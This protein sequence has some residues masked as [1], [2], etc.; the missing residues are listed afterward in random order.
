MKFSVKTDKI[1]T[2]IYLIFS[3]I[4]IIANNIVS[5]KKRKE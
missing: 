3:V 5:W 1:I 4:F 2:V